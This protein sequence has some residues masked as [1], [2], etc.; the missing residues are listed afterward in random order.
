MRAVK[1][2][3]VTSWFQ[4]NFERVFCVYFACILSAYFASDLILKFVVLPWREV[5]QLAIYKFWKRYTWKKV[6]KKGKQRKGKVLYWP[7]FI[8]CMSCLNF[9]IYVQKNNLLFIHHIDRKLRWRILLKSLYCIVNLLYWVE[10]FQTGAWNILLIKII[11]QKFKGIATLQTFIY[12][13]VC[14]SVTA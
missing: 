9:K 6:T 8:V 3:V 10:P 7:F 2:N 13:P 14:F 11:H 12:K 5:L 1:M 4:S